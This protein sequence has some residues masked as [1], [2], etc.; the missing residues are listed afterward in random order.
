[1]RQEAAQADQQEPEAA[2]HRAPEQY[3][4][5]LADLIHQAGDIGAR[6]QDADGVEHDDLPDVFLRVLLLG[7]QQR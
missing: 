7:Q 2:D 6:R 1:M 5:G 4:L 3:A